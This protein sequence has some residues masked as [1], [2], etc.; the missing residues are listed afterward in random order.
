MGGPSAVA[1]SYRR[2]HDPSSPT[3]NCSNKPRTVN[4][5]QICFSELIFLSNPPAEFCRTSGFHCWRMSRPRAAPELPSG[6]RTCQPK[7]GQNTISRCTQRFET[8]LLKI[9]DVRVSQSV[10]KA[11]TAQTQEVTIV[12]CCLM[13]THDTIVSAERLQTTST[14]TEIPARVCAHTFRPISSRLASPGTRRKV[15]FLSSAPTPG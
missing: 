14:N 2:P 5:L 11:A 4:P 15:P 7:F 9:S 3:T 10:V 6:W 8:R 1:C 12:H 13:S